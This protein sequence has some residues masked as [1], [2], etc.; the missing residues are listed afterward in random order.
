MS[1]RW[2]TEDDNLLREHVAKGLSISKTAKAMS[3]G[4]STVAEHA[5]Q[6]GLSWA[7]SAIPEA[8]AAT[9]ADERARRVQFRDELMTDLERLRRQLFSPALVHSFGGR[10]NTFATTTLDQPT[11]ADQ[12]RLVQAIAAGMATLERLAAMDA[13]QGVSDAAGMLDQI[14]KAIAKAAEDQAALL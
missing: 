1:R 11:I 12:L 8:I 13:D 4:E 6:L 2:G 5:K 9:R 10:D 14:A 7:R 3:R